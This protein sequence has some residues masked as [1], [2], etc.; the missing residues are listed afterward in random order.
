MMNLLKSYTEY[1]KSGDASGMAALFAENAEFN[2]EAPIKLGMQA[3]KVQ[4]RKNIEVFFREVFQGGGL[5]ITNVGVNGNAMRYDLKFGDKILLCLATAE[6]E[7]NLLK[8]YRVIA[9]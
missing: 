8:K 2:D 1:V 7:N 4:G 3:I 6:E 5:E 9:I